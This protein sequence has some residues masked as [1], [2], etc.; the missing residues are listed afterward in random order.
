MARGKKN[1]HGGLS[2]IVIALIGYGLY[3]VLSMFVEVT[4]VSRQASHL[5]SIPNTNGGSISASMSYALNATNDS[6]PPLPEGA[7]AQ[8]AIQAVTTSNY[9]VILDGSGSMRE[10]EC[11]DGGRK[12]QAAVAALSQFIQNVPDNANLGLTVFDS[13]GLS[14]RIPLGQGNRDAVRI[15]LQQVR[16]GG[17]TP[18]R[19]AISLGYQQLLQ[20]GRSQLGYGDYHLVVVT[21]GLPDPESENPEQA[22]NTLLANTPVVLHTIGFCIGTDHIL[23]QPGRSYYTAANSPEDLRKGLGDVLAEAPA[24]DV[25]RFDK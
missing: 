9:Y 20:Q 13:M 23:N 16:S 21:D 14:E 15:A 18:L 4:P 5:S 8:I 22:V 11:S 17:G 6:W 19:S 3:R 12:I 7:S 2:W 24:F 25:T 1:S 10:S